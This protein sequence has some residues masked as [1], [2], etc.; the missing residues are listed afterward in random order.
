M[1]N[2]YEK[3]LKM[4]E[5]LKGRQHPIC[6]KTPNKMKRGPF[7][8]IFVLKKCLTMPKKVGTH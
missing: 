6:R 3:S 1:K 8:E 2:S 5:K 7:E 4:P